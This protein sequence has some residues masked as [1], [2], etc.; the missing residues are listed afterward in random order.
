MLEP[1]QPSPTAC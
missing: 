1:R